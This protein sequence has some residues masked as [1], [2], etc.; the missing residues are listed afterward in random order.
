MEAGY[1]TARSESTARR[2]RSLRRFVLDAADPHLHRTV[3]TGCIR[4]AL[5]ALNERCAVA[6]EPA[7]DYVAQNTTPARAVA[8]LP[9]HD[10]DDRLTAR[11]G[12]AQKPFGF[13]QRIPNTAPVQIQYGP[14][15]EEL[16]QNLSQS[17]Q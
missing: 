4:Q 5:I 2:V 3:G 15:A 8:A 12:L 7:R 13:R 9:V 17:S 11:L 14:N 10:A 6:L 16:A 1:G